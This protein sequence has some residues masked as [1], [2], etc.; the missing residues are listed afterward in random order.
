MIKK[1]LGYLLS[2][3]NQ[4]ISISMLLIIALIVA[5][6]LIFHHSSPQAPGIYITGPK[7]VSLNKTYTYN[8]KVITAQS[9]NGATVYF[10]VA[11]ASRNQYK[12]INIQANK[13]W[14]GDFKIT[15]VPFGRLSSVGS[16]VAS[17]VTPPSKTPPYAHT[18][19]SSTFNPKLH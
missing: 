16:I 17:V 3:A 19:L 9:Y 8:V 11:E 10:Y 12:T 15:F 14:E 5:L 7:T 4:H 2:K 6:V 1:Y 13:P 18:I